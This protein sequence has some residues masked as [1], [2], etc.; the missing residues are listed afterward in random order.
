MINLKSLLTIFEASVIFLEAAWEVAIISLSLKSN[1]HMQ[2]WPSG[3]CI[4]L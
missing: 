3:A 2:I 1:Y 4:N